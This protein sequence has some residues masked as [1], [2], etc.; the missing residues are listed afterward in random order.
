MKRRD[1]VSFDRIRAAAAATLGLESLWPAQEEAIAALTAGR[2]TLALLPTGA[3]KSAI[4]QVGGALIPGPTVVVSPLIALQKD[5]A[6]A[7]AEN[8]AGDAAMLNSTLSKTRREQ[9][10]DEAAE[11][12]LEFVFLTPEQL[13]DPRVLERLRQVG[14]SLFVV[15]EAHCISEW[16]HDFRPDYLLL[17]DVIEA[18]GHPTVLALTATAPEA[19]REEIIERLRMR[20]PLVVAQ[21]MDR[22][23]IWLGVQRFDDERAKQQA[24]IEAVATQEKPGIVYAA[25]R[26][27]A[28]EL[29]SAF[30]AAG[31]RAGSITRGSPLNAVAQPRR[32]S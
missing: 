27:G 9:L 31:I 19:T 23:N 32:R 30:A 3:G 4:Y 17:G 25:T 16:G 28:A 5:Q 22:P 24:L 26:R 21:G 10:L 15:D 20:E 2:D 14:P 1:P 12:E 6:D 18:L 29:S 11:G 8:E 13:A 7:L